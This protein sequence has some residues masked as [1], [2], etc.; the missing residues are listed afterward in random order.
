MPKSTKSDTSSRGWCFTL[1]NYTDDDVNALASLGCEYIVYGKEV[2]STGTPHLQGYVHFKSACTFSALRKKMPSSPHIEPRMGTVDQAIEYCEKDGNMYERGIRPKSKKQQGQ[3][4]STATKERWREINRRAAAGDE[5]WLKEN[6]PALYHKQLAT[7][8]THRAPEITPMD[9]TDAD[10]PHEWWYGPTGTGKTS[11]AWADY[12]GF[13]SKEQNKWW[14]N[15]QRQDVVVI[16]EASPKT[17]EHLASRIK[18]WCDRY[19]FPGEIKGG[20]I[21]GLRPKKIIITSNYSIKDCFPSPQDYEPLLRRFKVTD[22][23]PP[24][25]LNE[26]LGCPP[27]SRPLG[28]HWIERNGKRV[29]VN[30]T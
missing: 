10:T 16:E 4:G 26:A 24:V 17:M 2:A 25:D 5:T 20:R 30:D 9:Y 7:F 14:C 3:L 27:V 21:E 8:R 28:G 15:Y 12:P 13:Y 1:N 19:P 11:K 18:V 22:F 6:E 29:F 23:T